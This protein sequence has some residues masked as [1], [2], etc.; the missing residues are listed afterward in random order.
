LLTYGTE[1]A[2]NPGQDLYVINNTFIN[3]YSSGGNFILVGSTV[4]Q[5]ALIQN[6]IFAGTGTV[7][8]Q[9]LAT[10]KTNYQSLLPAFVDRAN[11]DLRP[12]PGAPFIDAGSAPGMSATGVSL[13]PVR[14]Y[15]HVA[16]SQAR[17]VAGQLDIGAYEAA[18][19]TTTTTTL[20][21]TTTTTQ[22]AATTTQ[23]STTTTQQASTTTTQA[24]TSTT[25]AATTTTFAAT[26][27]TAAS[28]TT[29]SSATTTTVKQ[30][31]R[32]WGWGR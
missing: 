13:T 21:A 31:Q 12:A 17:A 20:A 16:S 22:A 23:A 18:V 28:T 26:T 27:T 3:D 25:R 9:A 32:R 19:A 6:N 30:K 8:N 4:T 11:Y 2:S 10:L 5:P 24:S 29:T 14:E 1:G 15:R 7:T